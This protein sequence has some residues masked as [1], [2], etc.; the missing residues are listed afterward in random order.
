MTD[1]VIVGIDLGTTNSEVA[2]YDNGVVTVI[3]GEHGG[4]MPSFVGLDDQG[5]LLV[6]VPARNQYALY[7][8]R[9]IRS[10][11]RRMG[12]DCR[13]E[14][15][16][17]GYSPQEISAIILRQL[18][19]VAERHLGHTVRRAVITVPAYFSDGQRQAT[20]EAGEIAGLE[21]VK[22]I[23]EPT[24][25]ALAYEA[26]Q[27][28]GRRVLVY[29][30]GGGTFDV[31]V[32]HLQQGVIEVIA[33]HGNNHLGGDDFDQRI[34]DHLLS[35]LREEHGKLDLPRRAMARI[36]RAA[37]QAK[38]LLSDQP[39]ARIDEEFLLEKDGVPLHLR[40]ELSRADYEDMIAGF[41]DE[42]MEAVHAALR[43][44]SLA[45]SRID[46]ILLV[47][48]STRTPLIRERLERE[49]GRPVRA[50]LDPDLCVAAGAAMQAAIIGGGQVSAV[51]VDVTPYTFGTMAMGELDGM[52]SPFMYVPIIRRN[53]PIPVTKSDVFYPLH[54]G[55][56]SVEVTV[57]QGEHPDARENIEIGRFRV[58]GLSSRQEENPI[59]FEFAL[60]ANGILQATATEKKTGLAKSITI[61]NAISRFNQDEL[62]QARDR[63]SNLF[64]EDDGEES[65]DETAPASSGERNRARE[66]QAKSLIEKAQSLFDRMGEDDKNE[67]QALIETIREELEQ[68]KGEHLQAAMDE[69][70][71]ILYYLAD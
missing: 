8:E 65:A 62:A 12:E 57:Y 51:L 21:V 3:E 25:A 44:A 4:I 68:G 31:S 49:I 61:D 5:E 23:N 16:P 13:L 69:L 17:R 67:V 39:Y 46:E 63:I 20:R 18:K 48:G 7:P 40:L 22:I 6:G 60:D 30:L 53:T 37:E 15:G 50:D 56:P 66:V 45:A 27:E 36:E 71:D 24:A 70:A 47:G 41:V 26:G 35:H 10:V 34:V 1:N 58:S 55:Q 29:D 64:G 59:L 9:T 2:L 28:D 32:A 42:T 19:Q 11:K 54:P 43:D 52:Y 14:L 38:R 33:S